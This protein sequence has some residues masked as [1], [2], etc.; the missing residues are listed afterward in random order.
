M[1]GGEAVW[2]EV[3]ESRLI[4]I[5]DKYIYL[6]ILCKVLCTYVKAVEVPEPS[7]EGKFV[8]LYYSY[9]DNLIPVIAT[10][11]KNLVSVLLE[12]RHVV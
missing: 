1:L 8:I 5:V 10:R 9:V 2:E 11:N 7:H 3:D 4:A 6:Y 12:M